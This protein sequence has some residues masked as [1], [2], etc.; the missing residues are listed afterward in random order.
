MERNRKPNISSEQTEMLIEQSW[1]EN[2]AIVSQVSPIWW[3]AKGRRGRIYFSLTIPLGVKSHHVYDLNLCVYDLVDKVKFSRDFSF[4]VEYYI[5][6]YET[7]LRLFG[8][9]R[10]LWTCN[11]VKWPCFTAGTLLF[12]WNSWLFI[13]LLIWRRTGALRILERSAEGLQH[14][15]TA[16]SAFLHQENIDI[17]CIQEKNL[18]DKLRFTIRGYQCLRKDRKDRHKGGTITLVL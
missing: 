2:K 12:A 4:S 18:T 13:P 10:P 14:K 6:Y 3:Q 7:S 8:E 5:Q 1:A 17:A 15:K 11:F 9:V 16:L